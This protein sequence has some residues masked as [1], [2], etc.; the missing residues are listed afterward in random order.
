MCDGIRQRIILFSKQYSM[1]SSDSCVSK[2][3]QIRM[4]IFVALPDH[5]PNGAASLGERL[6]L[7]HIARSPPAALSSSSRFLWPHR[8]FQVHRASFWPQALYIVL[9]L[10]PPSDSVPLAL[11]LDTTRLPLNGVGALQVLSSTLQAASSRLFKP[12]YQA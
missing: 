8:P 3:S 5:H 12:G 11:Y 2:P 9:S 4:D 1:T 10:P 7:S 6:R